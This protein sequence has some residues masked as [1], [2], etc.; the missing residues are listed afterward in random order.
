MQMKKI[1]ATTA[2]AAFGLSACSSAGTSGG[3]STSGESGGTSSSVKHLTLVQGVKGDTFYVTMQCGAQEAAKRLGAS[4]DVT[5][6]DQWDVQQQTQVVTSVTAKRPDGLLIAPVDPVAMAAPLQQ[7][8]QG[9]SQI[10]L[11]DT[12]VDDPSIG[13]TRISSNN[14]QGGEKAAEAL[15]KLVGNKGSVLILSVKPGVTTTDARIKGFKRG[16]AKHPGI[17]LIGPEYTNDEAARAASITTAQLS[18]HP[19][20]AGVF[21]ANV[22]TSEGAAT[23]LKNAGKQGKVKIVSFDA[24]PKQ[25]EDLKAGVIDALVAQDPYGIGQQGVEQVMHALLGQATTKEI[26]T[27]LAVIDRNNMGDP[28]VGKYIYRSSC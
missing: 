6:P 4:L 1:V 2:M 17:K 26:A 7:A 24:G 23:G 9:G 8:Q 14:E 28:A 5:G 21:A 22:V 15:A 10:A 18:A 27:D 20:L 25:M 12:S 13:L 3:P 11:V 19:D 16:I